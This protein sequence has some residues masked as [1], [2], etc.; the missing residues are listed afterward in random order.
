[1][2]ITQIQI[3]IEAVLG[4][5]LTPSDISEPSK[6]GVYRCNN[7]EDSY[8][9]G[10]IGASDNGKRKY[11]QM[12]SNIKPK[13]IAAYENSKKDQEKFFL[14]V[15]NSAKFTSDDFYI[16]IE[17][18]EKGGNSSSFEINIPSNGGPKDRVTRIAKKSGGYVVYYMTYVPAKDAAGNPTTEILKQ[19]LYSFD[20][21]PFSKYIT[22]LT[23]FLPSPYRSSASIA[24]L[25]EDIWPANF[26]IAGAPGT[27]KSFKVSEQV[28]KAIKKDLF[29]AEKGSSIPY[30]EAVFDQIMTELATKWGISSQECLEGIKKEQVRRV[31]FFEDYSYENFIGCY[32]PIPKAKEDIHEIAIQSTTSIDMTVS[33]TT[34]GMQIEY[35]YEAGPFIETYIDAMNNPEKIYFL[36]IEEINRA[37]A[38]SV[39][40][41][42]F[43]LLDRKNGISEYY[44]TPE[45]SLNA[46]LR[47]KISNY[48]S[49]MRLPNNMY[50][51]ATMNN[52][53][54]GVFPL[55]AAFK[56]R[57]G[58]LYLDVNSSGKDAEITIAKAKNV[59]W[60][61]F[62][63][64]LNEKMLDYSTEDKCI[65][66]W[67]FKDEE[68]AQI[69]KYY[70]ADMH[71]RFT[72]LNPLADKLLIY[73][74]NDVCRMNP[75]ILFKDD[76][77]SMPKIREALLNG[78]ELEAVLNVDW[79]SLFADDKKW[80][81]EA[82]VT[83]G[84]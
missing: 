18:L 79:E 7:G 11:A 17:L 20:S 84:V 34:K 25:A 32:K 28:E 19:Y 40:G 58:Y 77:S 29:A 81:D 44:I 9:I 51:W 43:Q 63:K 55:D 53:D 1:M 49:V 56:R 52:A 14:M 65:G 4:A 75:Q 33:G 31:T 60:N 48:D 23:D 3:D 6:N 46:Y 27:G 47:E 16:F 68:F 30:D 2:N 66:A 5:P 35:T 82:A 21:R 24:T 71:E 10:V 39:F 74:M 22:K 64:Y 54:Q 70:E 12:Q 80:R 67:Y 45:S 83:T 50:I 73:L 61:I 15:P 57:W 41:D 78:I 59:R 8:V 72:M 62:R 38:A 37:K 26:L 36:I 13:I 69:K 76:Y 42:M